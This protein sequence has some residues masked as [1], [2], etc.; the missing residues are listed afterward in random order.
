LVNKR[1]YYL[2]FQGGCDVYFIEK[3][4]TQNNVVVIDLMK[5]PSWRTYL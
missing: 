3:V 1:G 2:P 5:A 4:I